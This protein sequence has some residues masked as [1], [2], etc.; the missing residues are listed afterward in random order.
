MR[1]DPKRSLAR[2]LVNMRSTQS[3]SL[4]F[5]EG[6]LIIT[7]STLGG[8]VIRLTPSFVA[9]RVSLRVPPPT[10]SNFPVLIREVQATSFVAKG[11][12]GQVDD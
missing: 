11:Q 1:I 2:L 6:V 12:S 10:L 7:H 3:A 4:L 8:N 9:A 5:E